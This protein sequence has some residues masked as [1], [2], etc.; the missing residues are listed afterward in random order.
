VG[1]IANNIDS[2]ISFFLHKV[3]HQYFTWGMAL[4]RTNVIF[5]LSEKLW[6]KK[7]SSIKFNHLSTTSASIWP[8]NIEISKF[9]FTL[10]RLAPSIEMDVSLVGSHR[11][12]CAKSSII[13]FLCSSRDS[14]RNILKGYFVPSSLFFPSME[15]FLGMR[16][17]F[18]SR[19][20]NSRLKSL[21]L[22]RVG[23]MY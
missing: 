7:Y 18:S 15:G 11:R 5:S 14:S 8:S 9:I 3:V 1:A 2:S 6:T 4:R 22:Y 21:Y 16:E 20:T 19:E 12:I 13:S 10:K 23:E 17:Q